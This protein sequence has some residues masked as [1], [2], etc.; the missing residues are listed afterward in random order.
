MSRS[1]NQ[2]SIR[3]LTFLAA[4]FA[5][6]LTALLSAAGV[7]A[8]GGVDG[9]F[10]DDGRVPVNFELEPG[11]VGNPADF[12]AS[13]D[14]GIYILNH[15]WDCQGTCMRRDFV[16]RLRPNG[17]RDWTYGDGGVVGQWGMNRLESLAV[18]ASGR[19][20]VVANESTSMLVRRWLPDG[21]ADPSFSTY[22]WVRFPCECL[23][24]SLEVIRS[25][26][27]YM[28]LI[29]RVA[30][31]S[32]RRILVRRLSEKGRMDSSFGVK[33]VATARFPT[34][35][36]ATP[37]VALDGGGLAFLANQDHWA[38]DGFAIARVGRRGHFDERFATKAGRAARGWMQRERIGSGAPQ[39]LLP[40]ADGRLDL[41]GADSSGGFMLRL[42]RDGSIDRGFGS[43]GAKRIKW[44]VE[45]AVAGPG[46]R[47]FMLGRPGSGAAGLV[48]YWIDRKG[49]LI[50][51][52]AG[53]QGAPV[54]WF[55]SR[56]R[57]LALQRGK[58]PLV[59][60]YGTPEC[61]GNCDPIGAY[62]VRMTS[63]APE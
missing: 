11:I 53:G 6:G 37:A 18:D 57:L 56:Q 33:G 5:L 27:G 19:Q 23:N 36:A 31:P 59:L 60:E 39:A 3:H 21:S 50:R 41:L 28:Y 45:S 47:A 13:P 26:G 20:V 40:R 30:A 34:S 25:R 58:K 15:A 10:G 46:G 2:C 1:K 43:D 24:S 7:S 12:A 14:G 44:G 61:R 8:F 63:W 32:D 4:L 29:Q 17:R 42:R 52:F 22:G 62:L 51:S 49:A 35:Y 54:P 55:S 16:T 38:Q 9:S 48:G